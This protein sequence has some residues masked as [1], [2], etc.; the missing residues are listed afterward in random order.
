MDREQPVFEDGAAIFIEVCRWQPTKTHT[1]H[2]R[3][4]IYH[5][6][7]GPKCGE[8]RRTRMDASYI[9]YPSGQGAPVPEP[10]KELPERIEEGLIEVEQAAAT[11]DAELVNVDPDPDCG[12]VRAKYDGWTVVYKP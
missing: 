1:D 6:P 12:E 5:E 3:D 7:I 9:W 10:G 2:A 11:D 4:E 8:E